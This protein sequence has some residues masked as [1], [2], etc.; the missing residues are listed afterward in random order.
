MY[1]NNDFSIQ[2]RL[3]INLTISQCLNKKLRKNMFICHIR[4]KKSKY[5]PYYTP[6]ALVLYVKFMI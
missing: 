6:L 2:I 4:H 1:K 3:I 5:S